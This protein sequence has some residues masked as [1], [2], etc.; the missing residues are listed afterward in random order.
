MNFFSILIL[1]API[2]FVILLGWFAGRYGGYDE[3]SSKGISS[4]VTKYALPAHFLASTLATPKDEFKA[5][6]PLMVTLVLGIIGFYIIVL[7]VARY[8]FSYHLTGASMF[9][10]NSAQPTFAFMGISV[11]GS[12]YGAGEVAIPIAIT[13]IVVNALLDPLSII[14]GT[15]GE[16]AA[17]R[18]EGLGKVTLKAI[19]HGLSVPLAWAPLLGTLLVFLGFKAPDLIGNMLDMIGTTTSGV[20]L[21]AVGVTV[22]I[23]KIK[24]SFPAFSIAFLKT[25]VQPIFTFGIALLIGLTADEVTKSVLLVAFPGSAVAVMIS[26]QFKSQEAETASA[27][28]ISAILS[29]ITLPILISLLV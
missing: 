9:S 11:L 16:K 8:V 26:T 14:I 28:V 13:G 23:K 5:E 18:T 12:L 24:F 22:G 7:L 17:D 4:F 15:I 21:F 6:I 25:V 1:L 3:K 20:A 29:L 27:F 10:L 2:F 19:L